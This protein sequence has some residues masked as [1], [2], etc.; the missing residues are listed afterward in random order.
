M[1]I[2]ICSY[3]HVPCVCTYMLTY[4]KQDSCL[5]KIVTEARLISGGGRRAGYGLNVL[6]YVVSEAATRN[7]FRDHKFQKLSWGA[8]QTP[9]IYV[10]TIVLYNSLSNKSCS[11]T[12]DIVSP[13]PLT[14]PEICGYGASFCPYTL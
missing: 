8:P 7:G 12:H 9:L 13:T 3:V 11:S 1:Y 5:H 4:K 2:H 6:V 10:L 14:C